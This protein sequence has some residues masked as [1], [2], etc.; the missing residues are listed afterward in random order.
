MIIAKDMIG[1]LELPESTFN[2][3]MKCIDKG[4]V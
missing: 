2:N 3:L 1:R 4:K